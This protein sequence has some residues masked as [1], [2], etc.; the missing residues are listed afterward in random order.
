MEKWPKLR[1]IKDLRVSQANEV[2]Q[3]IHTRIWQDSRVVDQ[4]AKEKLNLVEPRS[5]TTI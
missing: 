5:T 4:L 2:L 1:D 3:K